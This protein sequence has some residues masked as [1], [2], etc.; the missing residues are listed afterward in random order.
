[1]FQ[2]QPSITGRI[3]QIFLRWIAT[4]SDADLLTF[5]D[6]MLK[7]KEEIADFLD[8][9]DLPEHIIFGTYLLSIESVQT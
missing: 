2:S 5:T 8:S 6:V 4:V 9:S 7:R 3:F 1:V